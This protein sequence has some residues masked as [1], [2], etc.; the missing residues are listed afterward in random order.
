MSFVQQV[1]YMTNGFN[2]SNLLAFDY[3]IAGNN[4]T[5]FTSQIQTEFVP[6]AGQKPAG[7]PWTADNSVFSA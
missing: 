7:I 1:G 2:V 6:T 5:G 4:I 3:A